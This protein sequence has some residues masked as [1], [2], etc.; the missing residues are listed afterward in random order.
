MDFGFWGP[1][2]D[3]INAFAAICG[4]RCGESSQT[5]NIFV[6]V[7]ECEISVG[8]DCLI[9]WFTA[10]C[11]WYL[12]NGDSDLL[13][14][15]GTDSAYVGGNAWQNLLLEKTH[16]SRGKCMWFV[17]AQNLSVFLVPLGL[18]WIVNWNTDKVIYTIYQILKFDSLH[19]R[20]CLH[21]AAYYGHSDCLQAIL[22]AAQSSPVAV[23]W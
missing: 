1:C 19:G 17:K 20:T 18:V 10:R 3:F 23:S 16:W 11:F 4:S 21:Y 14:V 8:V 9:L 13:I 6:I 7:C 12:L 5:G 22:S 15:N 2:V